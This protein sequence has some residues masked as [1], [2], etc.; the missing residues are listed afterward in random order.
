MNI[1]WWLPSANRKA[2]IRHTA[3]LVILTACTPASVVVF[4]CVY[5]KM[6]LFYPLGTPR[7]QHPSNHQSRPHIPTSP[8]AWQKLGNPVEHQHRLPILTTHTPSTSE[9]LY[10]F[11][12][13]WKL[14]RAPQVPPTQWI[15]PSLR[16]PQIP[17]T[18]WIRPSLRAPPPPACYLMQ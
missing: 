17:P 15:R 12:R 2:S 14:A 1:S 10:A 5:V 3:H 16:A 13:L 4:V 18:Q 7:D 6:C 8:V 11:A 9:A